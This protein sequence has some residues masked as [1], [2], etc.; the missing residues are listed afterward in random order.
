MLL[1]VI[2]MTF[3]VWFFVSPLHRH[4]TS[5]NSTILFEINK[6][7]K[8]WSVPPLDVASESPAMTWLYIST[9]CGNTAIK[10]FAKFDFPHHIVIVMIPIQGTAQTLT[11]LCCV[12]LGHWA[13]GLHRPGPQHVRGVRWRPE[14]RL[15][16]LLSVRHSRSREE[17]QAWDA[18]RGTTGD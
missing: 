12:W 15:Q 2:L 4:I 16:A 18:H 14:G 10:S 17:E 9:Y 8:H 5:K 6:L 1:E 7:C 11:T 3:K 13:G